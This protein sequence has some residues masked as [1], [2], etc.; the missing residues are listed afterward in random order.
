MFGVRGGAG[1]GV[2]SDAPPD[3]A[4][5]PPPPPPR[6]PSTL[7][8][9]DALPISRGWSSPP[10]EEAHHYQVS[11]PKTLNAIQCL[12]EGGRGQAMSWTNIWVHFVHRHVQ[13]TLVILEEGNQCHLQ[14]SKF[15]IFL[16]CRAL[17]VRHPTTEICR[18]GEEH[19]HRQLEAEEVRAGDETALTAYGHP[20]TVV[21]SFKYLEGGGYC[22][23]RTT[24]G[25]RLSQISRRH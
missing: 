9:H 2:P 18:R 12:V 3:G 24:T 17:N 13:D 19:K 11:F 16:S 10:P 25:R 6:P 1:H 20:L 15:N 4:P 7:S 5:P 21:P 23:P 8:P 14:C 22:Q